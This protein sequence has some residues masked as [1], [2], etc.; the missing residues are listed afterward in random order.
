MSDK[1]QIAFLPVWGKSNQTIPIMQ[2]KALRAR[3]I[4]CSYGEHK[5]LFPSTRTALKHRCKIIHYDWIH[6]YTLSPG[7][8][9]SL[10][11]SILFM[12]DAVIAKYIFGVRFY[13]T[14]H[15]LQHHD[16]RPRWIEQR[17]YSSFAA[18][19]KKVRLLGPGIQDMICKHL[20]ITPDKVVVIPEGSFVDWY[21]IKYTPEKAREKLGINATAR[22]VLNFGLL[23]PYKGIEQLIAAFVKLENSN[24]HLI[25]AGAPYHKEY[26][27]KLKKIIS[28]KANITLHNRHIEDDEVQLY[29]AAADLVVLPFRKV[30]NSGSALLAMGFGKAVVA[31]NT[32]L[33]PFRLKH[34]PELLFDDNT[35]FESVF[36]KA[37]QLPKDTLEDIGAKNSAW[38]ARFTW[39]DFAD[40]MEAEL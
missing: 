8:M 39:E 31:P 20:S 14:V 10:L 25:I 13:W 24:A 16:P 29:F 15:N 34:Q 18:L 36:I 22:V 28:G 26:S 4:T 23:R 32:G 11:K 35:P 5:V 9:M 21:P 12:I 27:E 1:T 6:T 38:A 30:L 3:G 17:V 33:L 40:F 2:M 19:C 37:M 7:V